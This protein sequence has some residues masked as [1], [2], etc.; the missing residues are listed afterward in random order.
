MWNEIAIGAIGIVIGAAIAPLVK[1]FF[2]VPGRAARVRR[3]VDRL[4]SDKRTWVD[5]RQLEL[6]R[7]KNRI[8]EDLAARGIGVGSGI[9]LKNYHRAEQKA[10]E[11]VRDHQV[12]AIRATE[13]AVAELGALERL[14]MRVTL[15]HDRGLRVEER[16]VPRSE[17]D[18]EDV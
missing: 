18:V 3:D 9:H 4:W 2:P 7:E 6:Q 12:A 14:W 15:P 16:L 5:R 1:G 11:D 17:R 8:D 13:D 10:A